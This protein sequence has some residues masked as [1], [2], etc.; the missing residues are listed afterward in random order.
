[1]LRNKS[2]STKSIQVLQQIYPQSLVRLTKSCTQALEL[3][4]LLLDI[5]TGDEVVLP[6][7]AYVSIA[8][9]FAQRGA[10]LV[11]VDIDPFTLNIDVKEVEKA[12]TPKTK[13][14]VTINYAG[15]AVDYE[16]LKPLA[17]SHNI[18]IVEDNAMGINASYKGKP[19]GS[20]GDIS[21]ISF[22]YLKNISCGE[23]GALFLNNRSYESQLRLVYENGTNKA[24]FMDGKVDKYEWR[25]LGSNYHLSEI[26]SCVLYKQLDQ[27]ERL[28]ALRLDKWLYY[29]QEFKNLKD[30]EEIELLR[31]PQE[32][33]H[34]GH[35]FIVKLKDENTRN[36][37]MHYL[38]ENGVESAFHYTP[39]HSSEFGTKAGR[40][41]GKDTYT[42]RESKRILR[43]PLY[44]DMSRQDQDRVISLVHDFIR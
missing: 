4:A 43:L 41:S 11:F 8:T 38:R 18:P 40:F 20:F 13:A 25:S 44:H 7:F 24:D 35:A 12:I 6:S 15:I 42:T 32:C 37:M 31:V 1:M 39:L 33:T 23:G 3:S 29:G 17:T 14:I 27:V 34:N 28:T 16:T 5:K 19:L 2:Y 30:K 36:S 26:L 21:T 9:A 22:D 10:T